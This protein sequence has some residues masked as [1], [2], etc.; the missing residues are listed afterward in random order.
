M[1]VGT[2]TKK[3]DNSGRT[4]NGFAKI[5]NSTYVEIITATHEI[6]GMEGLKVET[7]LVELCGKR[8]R[9]STYKSRKNCDSQTH[10]PPKFKAL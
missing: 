10:L 9:F 3:K 8:H 2:H 5:K 4:Q 7:K 1:C 6:N